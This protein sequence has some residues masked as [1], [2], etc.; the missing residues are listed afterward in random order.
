MEAAWTNPASR[1]AVG[2]AVTAAASVARLYASATAVS[3][4]ALDNIAVMPGSQPVAVGRP[5]PP[6]LT[7]FSFLF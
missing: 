2:A 4:G 7:V 3:H 5:L 1:G 6:I